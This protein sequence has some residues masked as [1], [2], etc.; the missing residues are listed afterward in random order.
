MRA[1]PPSLL[2]GRDPDLRPGDRARAAS[3]ALHR[4]LRRSRASRCR[5]HCR[6]TCEAFGCPILPMRLESAELSKIAIN[7]C[8]VSSISVANTLAELCEGIGAVWGEIA[9]ALKL[10]R[11]I[12]QHAYL[13][14]GLGI[15]GGNLERD[16]ATVIRLAQATGTDAGVVRAWLANSRHRRD[17]AARTIKRVLL[18]KAPEATV[19]VWGLAY[20]ENTNSVKNSPSLATLAPAA[21]HAPGAARP[22]RPRERG[23]RMPSATGAADPL[24]AVTGADALMILTPWPQYKAIPPAAIAA[25]HARP[26]RARPLW[27]PRRPCR[28]RRPVSNIIPWDAAPTS[29]EAGRMLEHRQSHSAGAAPRRRDRRQGLRRRCAGGATRRK[30][31]SRRWRSAA[32]RSTCCSRTRRRS[33]PR[34]S[35]PP[36]ASSPSPRW[37][38]SSRRACW[39]TTCAWCWPWSRHSPGRRSRTSSTSART[40]SMPTARCR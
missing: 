37:L 31:V 38:R 23:R 4:R 3:G 33:S 27:R 28:A 11:R 30:R 25:G 19:A 18:D 29:D 35:V 17:W 5:R 22:R 21:G 32:A 36:T 16:L 2:P 8:L 39:P 24:Q 10:D 12:G 7:C 40:P 20:K 14:P 15:A 34:C 13:S 6:P 1:G 9:P 26:D